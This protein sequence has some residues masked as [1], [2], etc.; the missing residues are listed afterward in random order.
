ME[1]TCGPCSRRG[2]CHD[3]AIGEADREAGVTVA[4][5]GLTHAGCRSRSVKE[6]T[7]MTVRVGIKG[8]GRI[9]RTYLRAALD[10]AE[11]GTQG[12]EMVAIN[13]I[14]S[15]ATLNERGCTNRL[16]DLTT[17]VADD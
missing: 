3:A 13:D 1:G 4:F 14:T 12:V 8:F 10:R 17:L 16:L 2:D 7:A 11:A 5:A 6:H 15:S 9:G